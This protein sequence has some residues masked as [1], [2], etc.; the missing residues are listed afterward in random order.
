MDYL[1]ANVS[2]IAGIGGHG[3]GQQWASKSKEKLDKV[4]LGFLSPP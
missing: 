2:I 3:G 1:E 4:V